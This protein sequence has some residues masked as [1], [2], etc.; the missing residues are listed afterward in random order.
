MQVNFQKIAVN[1]GITRTSKSLQAKNDDL[2][3]ILLSPP[4][5]KVD[6]NKILRDKD[7]MAKAVELV[8]KHIY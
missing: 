4:S 7:L 2:G 6:V 1:R 5:S 8:K 3:K